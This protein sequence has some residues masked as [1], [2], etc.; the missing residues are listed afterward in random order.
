MALADSAGTIGTTYT[1]EPF[2]KTTSAGP[3]S[4]NAFQFTGREND[5]TGLY[6]YRARYYHPTFG[7]FISQDPLGFAAGDTN[8]YAYVGNG[9]TNFSDPTGYCPL[10]IIVGGAIVGAGAYTLSIPIGNALSGR[11]GA[12]PWDGW[13][14]ADFGISAAM[15]AAAAGA[16]LLGLT[17]GELVIANSLISFAGAAW[18]Q[19][20][21][22]RRSAAELFGA[23]LFGGVAPVIPSRFQAP[24]IRSFGGSAALGV[25][26]G[27]GSSALYDTAQDK[28]TD[29][30]EW[31]LGEGSL[32]GFW[33]WLTTPLFSEPS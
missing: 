6:Y 18:S 29:A 25:V 1:Y 9:P 13:S 4:T 26:R 2:G 7:R 21:G 28:F 32:D 20:I 24:E 33:R 17:L 23:T 11:K 16:P 27:A 22:D 15:G 5:G 3:S 30:L 10:C 8:F 12:G 19:V 14:W 31:I